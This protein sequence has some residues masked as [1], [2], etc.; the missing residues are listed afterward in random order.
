[1]EFKIR[2][3]EAKEDALRAN[4][5]AIILLVAERSG[6]VL[7]H[8]LFSLVTTTPP[9]QE[10]GIG[11]APVAVPPNAQAQGIGSQLI[12]EGLCLCQE[13]EDGYCFVLGNPKYDQRFGF[14]E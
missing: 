4:G 9:S 12:R 11:L 5:K 7:G 8:I 6:Q 13:L 1:M 3:D 2:N 10:K 14:A